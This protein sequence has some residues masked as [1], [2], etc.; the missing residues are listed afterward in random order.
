MENVPNVHG[1]TNLKLFQDWMYALECMGY[2]NYIEDLSATDYGIPQTR[3]R[4]FMVSILGD[5]NYEFPH[6]I[7]LKIRL[8]DMLED[9]VEKKYY[10]TVEDVKRISS[11]KAQEKPLDNIKRNS[12]ISP[13]ITARG[14]GCNHSGMIL[15]DENLVEKKDFI[16]IKN[17]T[18]KGYLE[19][20]EGDGIDIC[21]RMQYHRGTVQ[22]GM[23]QTITT[24]GG[25]NVGV[26]IA[27]TS[28]LRIRKLTPRECFRLMGVKD[29]DF[30]NIKNEFNDSVLYHLAGDSIVVNVLMAIIGKLL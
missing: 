15:I 4:A 13:T 30:D 18:R 8:S 6:K 2:K 23:S 28:A 12:K 22:K 26:A 21:T 11:W 7:P 9:K 3:V 1:E 29:Q 24:A 25:N 20:T 16:P 14:A 19:A 5:Y 10:L 17:A 27:V